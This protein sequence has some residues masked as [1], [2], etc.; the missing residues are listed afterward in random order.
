MLRAATQIVIVV[1]LLSH[2][3][4]LA[5]QNNLP[6]SEA[7]HAGSNLLVGSGESTPRTLQVERK[8]TSV[9]GE[10]LGILRGGNGCG[11]GTP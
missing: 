2:Y 8:V 4:P 3:F 6:A 9:E 7:S 10:P 11:D 5:G 1:G